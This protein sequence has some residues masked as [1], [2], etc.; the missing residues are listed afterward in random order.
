[1]N[2]RLMRSGGDIRPLDVC[3]NTI[4]IVDAKHKFIV[5][6]EVTNQPMIL[7]TLELVSK[8]VQDVLGSLRKPHF[9]KLSNIATL[10]LVCDFWEKY[11]FSEVAFSILWVKFFVKCVEFL[12]V[13]VSTQ[14]CWVY[15]QFFLVLLCLWAICH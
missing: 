2:S 1:M 5:V 6:F 11:R 3:Y 7:G 14:P 4:T 8:K 13:L 15:S 9:R 10:F 12:F